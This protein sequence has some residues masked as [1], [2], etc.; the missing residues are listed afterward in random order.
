MLSAITGKVL[1][2][3]TTLLEPDPIFSITLQDAIIEQAKRYEIPSQW[4]T[5]LANC[6]SS[7]G[8]NLIGDHGL[9]HGVYQ[10]HQSTFDWFSKSYGES[11]DRESYYDQTKL[12]AWALKK[13]LG[14]HWSC[15][16]KTGKVKHL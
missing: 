10:Y 15:D 11:L 1:S 8:T 13:G 2:Q 16:Y 3:E 7:Y 12:T 5:N 4:L 9:A 6:E 14:S